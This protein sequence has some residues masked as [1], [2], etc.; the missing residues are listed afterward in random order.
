M[1]GNTG[2][3][4]DMGTLVYIQPDF[5]GAQFNRRI[6]RQRKRRTPQL[7]RINAKQQVVHH[8][9]T[10]EDNFNNILGCQPGLFGRT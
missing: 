7:H 10:H 6:N 3:H 1:A 2:Q 5:G 9:I 8:R 4:I